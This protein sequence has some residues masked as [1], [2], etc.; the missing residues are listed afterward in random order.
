MQ[1]SLRSI[2]IYHLC[3]YP[4]YLILAT[5]RNGWITHYIFLYPYFY[6]LP[7]FSITYPQP[8]TKRYLGTTLM[9]VVSLT[10]NIHYLWGKC[11]V[12]TEQEAGWSRD[13]AWKPCRS[14]K[15]PDPAT[16]LNSITHS[17]I[18]AT[19]YKPQQLYYQN[20]PFT[21]SLI[22]VSYL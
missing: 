17:S 20:S 5:I 6:G 1:T 11:L 21:V 2:L 9:Y 18:Q 14:E 4:K 12:P 19:H 13:L 8:G 15:S 7:G 10:Q 16:N 3:A 22:Y